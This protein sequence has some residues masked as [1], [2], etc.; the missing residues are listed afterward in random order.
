MLT[1]EDITYIR[2]KGTVA[3]NE[4]RTLRYYWRDPVGDH[5]TNEILLVEFLSCG[6]WVILEEDCPFG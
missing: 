3:Y 2:L 5:S 4:R 1:E 6:K